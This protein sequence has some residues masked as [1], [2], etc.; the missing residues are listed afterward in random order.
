MGFVPVFSRRQAEGAG[1]RAVS[2]GAPG[3]DRSLARRAHAHPPRR[4]APRPLA[5]RAEMGRDLREL[6]A[7]L[8]IPFLPDLSADEPPLCL[9][10]G[11]APRAG[12]LLSARRHPCGAGLVPER[13]ARRRAL[14]A[15]RAGL[16]ASR[17]RRIA[18]DRA[19]CFSA[20][21]GCAFSAALMCRV[22]TQI[23]GNLLRR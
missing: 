10:V 2:G 1:L 18:R 12:A 14:Q 11:L 5:S 23:T 7:A 9:H 13:R 20:P 17:R 21:W 22:S 19:P 4:R 6:R 16:T 3:R 15:V 8:Q